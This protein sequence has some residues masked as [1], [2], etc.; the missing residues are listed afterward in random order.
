MAT[1][2]YMKKRLS[3]VSVE[4]KGEETIGDL[5]FQYNM[6]RLIV[7]TS[8]MK[9]NRGKI[10]VTMGDHIRMISALILNREE[11]LSLIKELEDSI[12][13]LDN[14]KKLDENE[15][16]NKPLDLETPSAN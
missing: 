12:V 9:E 7:T 1:L 10:F 6:K 14:L 16:K 4:K 11:D 5:I 8:A 2:E 3:E 13:N 15:S